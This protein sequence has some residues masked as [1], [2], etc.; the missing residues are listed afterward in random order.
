MGLVLVAMLVSV[1]G[2]RADEAP[3]AGGRVF[4]ERC[5]TCHGDAG[6]GDGPTATALEPKPRNFHDPVFWESRTPDQMRE[7]VRHGKV[8]TAMPP[9][10]GA[11]SDAEIDAV[12]AHLASFRPAAGGEAKAPAPGAGKNAAGKK[13]RS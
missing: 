6:R 5:A 12:V 10:E 13:P 9:F 1:A 3:V 4:A 2:V 8:D 7:T 11:L